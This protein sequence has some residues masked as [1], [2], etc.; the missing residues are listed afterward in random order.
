MQIILT[1]D[2]SSEPNPGRT[3]IGAVL[4]TPDGEVLGLVSEPSG[5]GT[6]NTAEYTAVLR[7]LQECQRHSATRVTVYTDSQLVAQQLNGVYKVKNKRLRALHAQVLGAA[8][9]FAR[10]RFRWHSREDGRG[11]AAD[12][13]AKGG[14]KAAEIYEQ[15]ATP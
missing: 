12:A 11:P 2:G 4:E 5:Y 6:S 1:T 14:K 13:L 8:G 3:R 15:L 10:V 7:G 9:R